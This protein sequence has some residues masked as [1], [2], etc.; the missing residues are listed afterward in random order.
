MAPPPP[1]GG[2]VPGGGAPGGGGAKGRCMILTKMTL[3]NMCLRSAQ[4]PS[5]SLQ[6]HLIFK[7]FLGEAPQTPHTGSIGGEPLHQL[8]CQYTGS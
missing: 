7:I 1:P 6:E 3:E 4:V 2:G 5:E 8:C